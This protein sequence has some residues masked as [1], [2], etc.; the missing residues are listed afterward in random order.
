MKK[1]ESKILFAWFISIILIRISLFLPHRYIDDARLINTWM[2]VLLFIISVVIAAKS[3]RPQRYLYINFAIFFGFVLPLFS[4]SFVGQSILLN[5]EYASLYYHLYINVIGSGAVLLF[6]ILYIIADYMFWNLVTWKKYLISIA[7]TLVIVLLNFF[8]YWFNPMH[9]YS[10]E[11]YKKFQ[12]LSIVW[13]NLSHELN[14]TP[15]NQ[16]II[17]NLSHVNNNAIDYVNISSWLDKNRDYLEGGT[18]TTL[19]WKPLYQSLI[20][21]N[22]F[23][24]ILLSLFLVAIYKLD[25]PYHP[26][27]DKIIIFLMLFYALGAV[28]GYAA[29]SS[30]SIEHLRIIITIGQY[31]TILSFLFLVY[32]FHL[33]LRFVSSSV[34]A[35]YEEAILST[36]QNI[37]RWRDEIDTF[38]LKSFVNRIGFA[39]R[40]AYTSKENK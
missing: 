26:Y 20:V 36:P 18:S 30:P 32:I 19:F 7:V 25:K 22:L 2:Q 28:H 11:D 39:R 37:T 9:L 35:Y 3:C 10:N 24:F 27:V 4:S 33:N 15:N 6:P 34:N 5:Y 23:A 12:L 29:S 16:E 38:I 8:P 40:F 31:A 13:I 1:I 17:D 14:R 21:L